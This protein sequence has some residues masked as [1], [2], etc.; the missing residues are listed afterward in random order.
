MLVT[1]VRGGRMKVVGDFHVTFG[2]LNVRKGHKIKYKYRLFYTLFDFSSIIQHR[3]NYN[4]CVISI[5]LVFLR[6]SGF[7]LALKI[8]W[9]KFTKEMKFCAIIVLILCILN[10]QRLVAK[11]ITASFEP[12]PFCRLDVPHKKRTFVLRLPWEQLLRFFNVAGFADST[13]KTLVWSSIVPFL[14]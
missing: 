8:V 12:L 2:T 11:Y 1:L 13:G 10:C 14:Q 4:L 7:Y 9:H 6:P 3:Y 5:C